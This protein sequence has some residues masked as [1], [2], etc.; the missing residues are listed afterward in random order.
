MSDTFRCGHEKSPENT[1][2]IQQRW[3]VCRKCENEK[4]SA[5]QRK[6][7]A[8]AKSQCVVT[9][10]KPRRDATVASE[11]RIAAVRKRISA[12]ARERIALGLDAKTAT[13][14][15]VRHAQYAI[16]AENEMRDRLASPIE[17]AKA[18]LRRRYT[19]VVT[20]SVYGGSADRFRVGNH[21]DITKEELLDLAA[22]AA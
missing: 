7:R 1:K 17:Q 6:R 20:M 2:M 4:R 10:K 22:R 11:R 13:Q 16:A 9:P 8:E 3:G 15:A 12:K 14:A 5:Y 18:R 19:P 21:Q